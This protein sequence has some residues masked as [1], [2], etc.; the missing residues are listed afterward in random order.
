[1][2]TELCGVAPPPHFH[3]ARN[4]AMKNAWWSP[5]AQG[6]VSR[7][8]AAQL[9]ISLGAAV[10]W[11][12]SSRKGQKRCSE[13]AAGPD[14]LPRR[15]VICLH[16]KLAAWSPFCCEALQYHQRIAI[17]DA[18]NVFNSY[19]QCTALLDVDV[20]QIKFR[21]SGENATVS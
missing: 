8:L 7:Y 16:P 19:K 10:Q 1:V 12:W 17:N 9:V 6:Q 3:L 5:P 11:P 4:G 2:V 13:L 14:A 15:L 18:L 21:T 20:V